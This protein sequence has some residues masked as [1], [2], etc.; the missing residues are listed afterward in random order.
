M[1]SDGLKIDPTWTLFLDRDG[2]INR[3][4]VGGYVT[5]WEEFEFLPGAVEALRILAPAFGPVVV[6]SNQQGVGKG[7][8]TNRDVESIHLKMTVEVLKTGGRIDR[9]YF[10]PYLEEEG[11]GLRKPNPGMAHQA[12]KD[13]P[14][15]DFS[16]AVMVGDSRSDL[17]FGRNLSMVTVFISDDPE[18]IMKCREEYDFTFPDLLSFARQVK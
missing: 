15:I 6:V 16:R 7:L 8:M 17:A 3:R 10:S 11:S 5:R 9:V 4:I 13:F 12:R 2:V 14:Q 18:L 1:S